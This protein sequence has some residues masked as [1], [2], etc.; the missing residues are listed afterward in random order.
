MSQW[1]VNV[2][3]L[4][5]PCVDWKNIIPRRII[6]KVSSKYNHTGCYTVATSELKV[7]NYLKLGG[8]LMHSDNEWTGRITDKGTD[9][10]GYG[11]LA[12]HVGYCENLFF[13]FIFFKFRTNT[14]VCTDHIIFY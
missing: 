6:R 3:A 13:N 4:A 2:I 14:Y 5:E 9:P 8:A 11:Q 12:Y 7:A 1:Q 10:W